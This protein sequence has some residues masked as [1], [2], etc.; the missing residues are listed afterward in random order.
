VLRAF[1]D[2]EVVM[3]FCQSRQMA[4]DGTILCDSYIDYVADIS[5]NKWKTSYVNGGVDE[6]LNALSIKNTIPNVSAVVFRRDVLR[7][8]LQAKIEHLHALRVAGDWVTYIE[9]LQHGKISFSPRPLNSHRR[10][11][12]SVTLSSFNLSQLREIM[13]VQQMVRERFP[14]PESTSRAAE[15]YAERLF[16]QFGLA[17]EKMASIRLHP[18][19]TLLCPPNPPRRAQQNP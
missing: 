11:S 7:A 18:E 5:S 8:A 15:G 19:L 16:Q 14:V 13:S 3:S 10:H 6:I 9:V 1:D 2:P 17:T 4:S 12:S